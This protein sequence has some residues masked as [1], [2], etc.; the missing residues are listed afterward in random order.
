MV[1]LLSLLRFK[2]VVPVH[3]N[4]TGHFL[5]CRLQPAV[6]NRGIPQPGGE[7]RSSQDR[8]EDC[9]RRAELWEAAACRQWHLE[10]TQI[11]SDGT[12]ILC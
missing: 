2:C 9:D 5:C 7:G 10:V 8:T 3:L 11:T 4:L 6:P 12:E 1:F